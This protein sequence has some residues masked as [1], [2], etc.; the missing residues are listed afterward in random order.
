MKA[1]PFSL[2]L[3]SSFYA[4]DCES[5]RSRNTATDDRGIFLTIGEMATTI[6]LARYGRIAHRRFL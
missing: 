3:D 1:S 4:C 5:S 6:D 2:G